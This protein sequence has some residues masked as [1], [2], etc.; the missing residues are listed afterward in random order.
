MRG[1]APAPPEHPHSTEEERPEE[2]TKITSELAQRIFVQV[3]VEVG[4]KDSK[5][6]AAN[7]DTAMMRHDWSK[8]C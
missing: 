3:N 4:N 8:R 1:P 5:H 7:D 2:G 6:N